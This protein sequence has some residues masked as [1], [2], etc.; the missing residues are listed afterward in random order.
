MVLNVCKLSFCSWLLNFNRHEMIYRQLYALSNSLLIQ[1]DETFIF[2]NF[3]V[4]R[5]LDFIYIGGGP[6][7][8]LHVWW[9]FFL[10]I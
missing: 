10:F 2:S 1:T 5:R 8:L 3:E 4:N 9:R 7:I 6:D